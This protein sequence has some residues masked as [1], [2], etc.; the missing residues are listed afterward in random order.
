MTQ[1]MIDL[2][3]VKF[4]SELPLA[5]SEELSKMSELRAYPNGHTVFSQ[6]SKLPGIFV[7]SKGNLKIY[8][9]SEKGKMQVVDVLK[10][11]QCIGEVQS[12]SDGVAATSAEAKGATECWI[13]PFLAIHQIIQR[14]PIVSEV[15]LRHLA[16]KILHLM[17]LIETLSLHSVPERVAQLI[18]SNQAD[19]PN[20]TIIEFNE[21][22]EEL[23]QYIGASREAFNR[24]LKLL[25]DLGF[26]QSTFPVVHI[27][28]LP[29]LQLYSKGLDL[30]S[31]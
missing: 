19:A 3:K 6:G 7:V 11:G 14:N 9:A 10:P 22:Q 12:F 4:L 26:I 20:N 17:P 15:I 8:R 31:G 24:A 13:I 27:L 28:D 16:A 5:E 18:L 30:I 23:A 1:S 29:K 21:T 25:S 2:R